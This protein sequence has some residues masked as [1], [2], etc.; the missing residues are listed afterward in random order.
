MVEEYGHEGKPKKKSGLDPLTQLMRDLRPPSLF[1]TEDQNLPKDQKSNTPVT[2]QAAMSGI[3]GAPSFEL[4][5]VLNSDKSTELVYE[6]AYGS[7]IR[8]G[9]DRMNEKKDPVSGKN[10]KFGDGY[11][12]Q[13]APGCA[14]IDI[15]AGLNSHGL[16]NGDLDEDDAPPEVNPNYTRDAARVYVSAQCDVDRLFNLG[17]GTIA[18]SQGK[19]A[20]VVKSDHTRIVG[21]ESVKIMTGTDE[22]NSFNRLINSVPYINLIAGDAPPSMMEPLAKGKKV[23]K[24]LNSLVD[25]INQLSAIVDKFLQFQTKF[26]TAIMSHNHPDPTGISIGV[27]S[28]AGPTGFCGGTTQQSW[29]TAVQGYEAVIAGLLCKKDLMVFK[30]ALAGTSVEMKQFSSNYLLSRQVFTS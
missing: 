7:L 22:T 16:W 11:G 13:G 28:G 24:S 14:A 17:K 3:D 1:P 26:N 27:L 20:V 23:L 8:I 5:S 21:R 25:R 2:D 18:P 10:Y 29:Q 19:S 4:K 15:I 6:S 9:R 30:G 12:P